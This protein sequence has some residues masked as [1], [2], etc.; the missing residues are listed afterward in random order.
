M[1][2][3]RKFLVPL[4]AALAAICGEASAA[5]VVSDIQQ[6]QKPARLAQ[7][8]LKKL[9]NT[10]DKLATYPIAGELHALILRNSI[11]GVSVAE[12]YSHRSHS[13]HSSHRSH[14]SSR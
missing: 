13:S 7:D 3:A 6:T 10:G 11:D 4:P 8:E 2:A 14:Y 9:L 1:V 12:H 5:P